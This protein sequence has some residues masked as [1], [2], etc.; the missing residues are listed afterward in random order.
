MVVKRLPFKAVYTM[1]LPNTVLNFYINT[2][3]MVFI[4]DSYSV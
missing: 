3:T 1:S 4:Q 2:L